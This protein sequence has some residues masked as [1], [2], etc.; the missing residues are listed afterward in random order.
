MGRATNKLTVKGIDRLPAGTHGDGGGLWLRKNSSTSAQWLY[1]FRLHGRT[2]QMGL[3]SYPIVSLANARKLRDQCSEQVAHSVDPVLERRR[4]RDKAKTQLASL[5]EVAK[6]AFEARKAELKDEGKAG[7][8]FGP[9]K[10]HVLPKIG[11]VPAVEVTQLHIRDAVSP[12]WKSKADTAR[13]AMN[14]LNITLKHAAALGLDVDLLAVEKAKALLG[15]QDHK[16]K[17]IPAMPWREVPAFY[18]SLKEDTPTQLALRLLILN[19]GPR[20]KPIRFLRTEHIKGDVW[21]VPGELMKGLKGKVENWRTPLSSQSLELIEKARHWERNGYLFPNASGR[22][23]ISDATMAR[24]M[25]RTGL[26]YR[27][28]GF[29]SSFRTWAAETGKRRD[30]AELCNAH[31]IFGA[32]EA[33]YIRTDFLDERRELLTAWSEIVVSS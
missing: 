26:E 23:V 17:N 15:K 31:K 4:E 10:L 5:A 29:R 7:R 14:R 16:A 28:H 21:T 12:I 32:V 27:P 33:A 22:G 25:E 30:I 8:W 19:P 11:S 9:L 13:K 6:S 2:R 24:H 20:S 3:G 1:R 18:C